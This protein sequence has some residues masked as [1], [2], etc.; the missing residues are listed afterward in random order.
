ML[1]MP[2]PAEV[3]GMEDATME[4]VQQ[5]IP[6]IVGRHRRIAPFKIADCGLWLFLLLA[7]YVMTIYFPQPLPCFL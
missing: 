1:S 4:M 3:K 6:L 5:C 2:G 7:T